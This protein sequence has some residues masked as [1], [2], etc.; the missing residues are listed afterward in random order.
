MYLHA[1][2]LQ[3]LRQNFSMLHVLD[4]FLAHRVYARSGWADPATNCAY[5]QSMVDAFTNNGINYG[6]YA[7]EYMWSSIM[8]DGCTVGGDHPLW[9]A[10]Y[11]GNPSL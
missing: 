5:Y 9:Y 4:I 7:S 10:H 6:T 1:C 11:D 2:S 8:G 3:V